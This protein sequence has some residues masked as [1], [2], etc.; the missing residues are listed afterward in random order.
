MIPWPRIIH[1]KNHFAEK[2]YVNENGTS[3]KIVQLNYGTSDF[4][5]RKRSLYVTEIIHP[6]S[7]KTYCIEKTIFIFGYRWYYS[8]Q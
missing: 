7:K 3:T 5:N 4:G 1:F 8:G 2:K 6:K